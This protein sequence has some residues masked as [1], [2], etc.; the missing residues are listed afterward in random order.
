[1]KP[2]PRRPF[3]DVVI[4]FKGEDFAIDKHQFICYS[5]K[6][7]HQPI[8]SDGISLESDVSRES[9]VEFIN[10][11]SRR[12]FVVSSDIAHDLVVLSTE[13]EVESLRSRVTEWM[14]LHEF[15][16]LIPTLF[17]ELKRN[18]DTSNTEK[19]IREHFEQIISDVRLLE[20]PLSAVSRVI[21]TDLDDVHSVLNFLK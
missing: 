6:F 21:R 8:P 16:L 12:E 15:E 18:I 19:K 10:A 14:S 13:L 7:R 20:L 4:H 2:L 1:M 11:C 9:V 5:A 17:L 3:S